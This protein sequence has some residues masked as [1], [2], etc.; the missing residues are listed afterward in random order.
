VTFHTD[1][2]ADSYVGG[3]IGELNDGGSVVSSANK[4]DIVTTGGDSDTYDIGGIA[5]AADDGASIVDSYN[6]GS[7]DGYEYVGGLVGWANQS[8]D[9]NTSYN[10]GQVTADYYEDGI[11]NGDWADSTSNVVLD[12]ETSIDTDTLAV[13][14]TTAE[15][16][17]ASILAGLGWSIDETDAAWAVDADY[18]DGYPHLAYEYSAAPLPVS[19]VTF[20]AVS[21]KG[22]HNTVL[23]VN[24]Q[25]YLD[26]V[27]EQIQ[28]DDY[29]RVE[30]NG[31]S[32]R[33]T[34][35]SVASARTAAVVAYLVDAGV[36]ID[37]DVH[38]NLV[39]AGHH[40]NTV[41]VSALG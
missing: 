33:H 32:N 37:V 13:Q 30:I 27:A 17:D 39:G 18:Q 11:A 16:K 14:L 38:N 12:T 5:G 6:L 26:L 3:I 24:A 36:S 21:F 2:N 25:A 40:R 7:V 8:I 1:T 4:G 9:I 34:R 19:D 35:K 15:V 28:S 20:A 22:R 41:V 23:S 31:Y 10:A 29:D